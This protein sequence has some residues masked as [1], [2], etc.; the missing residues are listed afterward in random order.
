[1][2]VKLTKNGEKASSFEFPVI[3]GI[4]ISN[5]GFKPE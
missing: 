1:M 2:L 5:Y 4:V 3:Y